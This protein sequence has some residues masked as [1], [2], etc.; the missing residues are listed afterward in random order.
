MIAQ[1]Y[2]PLARRTLKEMP[3]FRQHM[4]HMG[5]GIA[6][7]MGELIDLAKKVC[8]YGKPYDHT[9][10]IEEA[11]DVMWYIANLMPELQVD[12]IYMQRALVKGYTQGL[13]TQQQVHVWKD[14][15]LG[16][17]LLNLNA[18]V[19]AKAAEL[20]RLS[21]VEAPGTAHAAAYIEAFAGNLGLIC[22]MLGVDPA[23][24]MQ[25]NIAKLA[26]R[27]GDKYTDVAALHRDLGGE[28]EVLEGGAKPDT[29]P[30]EG[31]AA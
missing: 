15:N 3:D 9:N 30:V 5:M 23:H 31:P 18:A 25:V 27:Y 1:E 20:H 13:G 6:G 24:A 7:E 8:V 22:G 12:A 2:A 29:G 21:H 10:A 16:E 19:S 4:I 26:K 28:R 17:I 11:G 14:C